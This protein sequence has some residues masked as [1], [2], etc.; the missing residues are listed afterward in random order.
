MIS[1]RMKADQVTSGS[2]QVKMTQKITPAT[3]SEVFVLFIF[4]IGF[5]DF[6][7]SASRLFGGLFFVRGLREPASASVKGSIPQDVD[8]RRMPDGESSAVRFSGS[9][10]DPPRF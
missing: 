1:R 3:V 5:S 6:G 4:S 9:S 8:A 2:A 10:P 7:G